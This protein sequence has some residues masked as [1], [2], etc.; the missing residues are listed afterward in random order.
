MQDELIGR[1]SQDVQAGLRDVDDPIVASTIPV[2]TEIGRAALLAIHIRGLD[3]I[4]NITAFYG[5][6]NSLGIAGQTLPF[7]L[8]LLQEAGWIRVSPSVRNIKSIEES[9]PIFQSLYSTLGQQWSAMRPGELEH[10]TLELIESLSAVPRPFDDVK[11]LMGLEDAHI[12]QLIDIGEL[13]GYLQLY[14]SK[15]EQRKILYSPLFMDEHPDRILD[16]LA[17]YSE[18]YPEISSVFSQAKSMPG[19]PVSD[20]SA[21]HPI[22]SEMISANVISAPAVDSSSGLHSFLFPQIRTSSD[23]AILNKAKVLLSCIRYGELFSTITHIQD[24]QFLLSRL[25]DT[26]LIG[27]TPHSNIGT[28]YRAAADL[29]IGF[30]ETHGDRYTFKLYDTPDNNAAVGLAEEIALGVTEEPV[31]KIVSPEDVHTALKDETVKSIILPGTNRAMNSPKRKKR[32]LDPRSKTAKRM[33]ADL[34]DDLR[35]VRRVT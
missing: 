8:N 23:T 30:I 26:K 5:F 9:V 27:R 19:L 7:V 21:S 28:Q 2:T 34:M 17:K 20:I 11:T 15:R 6:A 18:R 22:V 1:R 31:H 33:H 13:G 24:P 29:G 32:K 25:R 4:E 3:I 16:F 14:S 10:A 35:G 12:N